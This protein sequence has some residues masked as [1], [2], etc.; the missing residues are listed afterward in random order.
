MRTETEP[1]PYTTFGFVVE[2]NGIVRGGFSEISGLQAETELEEYREGGINDYVHKLAKLTK[3]PNLTLKRGISDR[4][5]LWRWYQAVVSG[6]IERKT[7][8]VMLR[9]VKKEEK[10]RWVFKDAYP[11]K[12]NGTD[13]NATSNTVFVESLE[14]AHHG[15]TKQERR[16][17]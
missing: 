9:D 11:V 1:D 8:S 12:W 4:E 14:F 16:G 6:F 2:I 3:Y 10:W 7:I 13:L 15:M 17:Q 5:D